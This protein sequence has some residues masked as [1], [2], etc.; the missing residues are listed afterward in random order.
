MAFLVKPVRW[1]QAISRYRA[2]SSGGPNFGYELCVRR[3]SEEQMAGLDL[4]SWQTAFNGAEV[5]RSGTLERF[6]EKFSA[7]G[8]R[9]SAFCCCY[10]MAETTLLVSATTPSAEPSVKTLD[11][12]ALRR[13]RAIAVHPESHARVDA[14]G[15]GRAS[16]LELAI[17]DP[18]TRKRCAPDEIG[19]IWV[20]GESVARGY[21]N[22]ARASQAAFGARI[23]DG[24]DHAYLRTGDLGFVD[25]TGELFVTGRL[26]DLVIL[27]GRNYYPTD[28]E[29]V[30]QAS[31]PALR[32]DAGAAFSIEKEDE[33][34]LVVVQEVDRIGRGLDP[35]TLRDAV[36]IAVTTKLGLPL[37]ELVLIK[38]GKLPKTSSGKV[39][40]S[41]C[42]D[43][44]LA[45]ALE[46]CQ[47]S[48]KDAAGSPRRDAAVAADDAAA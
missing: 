40:R 46:L 22:D 3:V 21:W 43:A 48:I 16:E 42:R 20:R 38:H 15:C 36:R 4:R 44:Y 10:G 31:H 13:H 41:A 9:K 12:E 19:E 35:E 8:F 1:L 34:A 33:E 5:V 25:E 26:K 32:R 6:A 45:G 18:K 24:G 37:H 2:T 11:A 17:V 28:I 30:V 29:A 47:P 27:R 14:V 23:A 7:C 39:R